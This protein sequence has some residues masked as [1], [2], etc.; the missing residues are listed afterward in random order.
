MDELFVKGRNI[1]I[2]GNLEEI[3]HFINSNR[4][5]LSKVHFEYEDID[6]FNLFGNKYPYYD[7]NK[8]FY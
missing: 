3:E 7:V 8:L 6:L 1:I 4:A 5:E 2:F